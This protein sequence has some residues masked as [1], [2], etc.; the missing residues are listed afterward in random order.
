MADNTD[1][2]PK[3]K[4][5]YIPEAEDYFEGYNQSLKN[6]ESTEHFKYQQL[7]YKLFSTHEGRE[8]IQ[9]TQENFWKQFTDLS[10]ENASLYMAS[11]EGMRLFVYNISLLVKAHEQHLQEV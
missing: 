3:L 10:K 6:I 5:P 1:D 11:L 7:T 9:K 4:N 8:W 2:K